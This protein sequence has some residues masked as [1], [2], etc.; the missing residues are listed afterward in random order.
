M[1]ETLPLADANSITPVALKAG[2]PCTE[3][4]RSDPF[5]LMA[6]SISISGLRLPL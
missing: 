5:S 2:V 4:A 3:E 1:L 6:N